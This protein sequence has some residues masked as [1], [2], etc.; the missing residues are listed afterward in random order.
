MN[1]LPLA[2]KKALTE[3]GGTEEQQ[4]LTFTLGGEMF[5]LEILNIKEIIE[6]GHPTTVPM[7][8]VP[9]G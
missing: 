8:P 5:A 3:T 9:A 7:M 6:Y 2:E 4:Y 1:A